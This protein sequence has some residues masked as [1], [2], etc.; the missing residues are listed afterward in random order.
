M[1]QLSFCNTCKN[2]I[3]CCHK[4]RQQRA[5]ND[6]SASH[7]TRTADYRHYRTEREIKKTS[8]LYRI[9][10]EQIAIS[11]NSVFVEKII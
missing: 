11:E 10:K 1:Y 7:D 6:V 2:V 3:K 9:I 8:N 4:V 5:Y